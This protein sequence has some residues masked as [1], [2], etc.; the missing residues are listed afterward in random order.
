MSKRTGSNELRLTVC[1]GCGGE[2][3]PV[4]YDG[5]AEGDYFRIEC[6]ECGASTRRFATL[7]E[8]AGAWNDGHVLEPPRRQARRSSASKRGA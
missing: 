1:P 6:G 7:D 3:I 2:G 5:G 4:R 8:A